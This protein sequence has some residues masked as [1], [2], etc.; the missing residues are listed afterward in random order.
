MDGWVVLSIIL[1]AIL[2]VLAGTA[3]AYVIIDH[4]KIAKIW[5]AT[6]VILLSILADNIEVTKKV[7]KKK[8]TAKKTAKKTTKKKGEK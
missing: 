1:H 3:I 8:P 4:K 5:S 6:E 2:G 7:I